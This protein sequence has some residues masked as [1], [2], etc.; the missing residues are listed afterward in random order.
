MKPILRDVKQSNKVEYLF[1]RLPTSTSA[2]VLK[3]S[4]HL[5]KHVVYLCIF[6]RCC[7]N[8]AVN[9]L[10]MLQNFP[11]HFLF[12]F[13]VMFS[14]CTRLRQDMTLCVWLLLWKTF[15]E[16]A[17]SIQSTFKS[18][19]PTAGSENSVNDS[20]NNTNLGSKVSQEANKYMKKANVL[21]CHVGVQRYKRF[22]ISFC[23]HKNCPFFVGKNIFFHR[24][25]F[26]KS[27]Q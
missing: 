14:L 10:R 19:T 27:K 8:P 21:T 15:I 25:Y 22:C 2:L 6:S 16:N 4:T 26:K 24:I 5:C 3:Y 23:I 7:G 13:Q 18:G 20:L 17:A 9:S 1:L 12:V 11:S